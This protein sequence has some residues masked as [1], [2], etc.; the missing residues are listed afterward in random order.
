M[1]IVLKNT[2]V[3][4]DFC[5]DLIHCFAVFLSL[6]WKAGLSPYIK[7]YLSNKNWPLIWK[8]KC[9]AAYI[10][11]L[12]SIFQRCS[13]PSLQLQLFNNELI[14]IFCKNHLILW[15]VPNFNLFSV[16]FQGEI[17]HT[18]LNRKKSNPIFYW[19]T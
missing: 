10:G 9:Q 17:I 12:K 4:E 19:M 3:V 18:S 15:K 11:K 1:A 14:E 5:L 2:S 16:K 8:L 6:K 7:I 13:N